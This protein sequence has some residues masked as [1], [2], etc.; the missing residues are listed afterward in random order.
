MGTKTSGSSANPLRLAKPP[1]RSRPALLKA[2]IAWKT[3]CQA[4]PPGS[5]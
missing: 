3:P 4:A 5:P 2:E 1:M